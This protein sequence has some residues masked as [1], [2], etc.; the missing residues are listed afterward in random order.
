MGSIK[1]TSGVHFSFEFLPEPEFDACMPE[2][3]F[4]RAMHSN[5]GFFLTDEFVAQAH[6]L[7]AEELI[8]HLMND[9]DRE[10]GHDPN[11]V[12][13]LYY[14]FTDFENEFPRLIMMKQKRKSRQTHS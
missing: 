4:V 2:Q 12:L 9:L 13:M 14:L 7:D 5:S 8:E 3:F 1:D 6:S 11:P 10:N